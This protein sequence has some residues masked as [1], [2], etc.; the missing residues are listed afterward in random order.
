[1]VEER[2]KDWVVEQKVHKKFGTLPR[3]ILYY[4]D[5]VSD[6]QYVQVK[7]N[8]LPLIEK[9]FNTA[10]TAL[11]NEGHIEASSANKNATVKITAVVVA[12]RHHVRFYPTNTR[13]KDFYANNH[14][15]T[16]VDSVVTSPYF[17]DFYLQSHAAIKGT[18]KPAHYFLLRN[19]MSLSIQALRELTN[20]LCFTYVRSTVP[21]SYA[22]PAYYADR[23]CDRGRLYLREFFTKPH[24]K[25]GMGRQ[26]KLEQLKRKEEQRRKDARLRNWGQEWEGMGKKRRLKSQEEVER[27]NKDRAEVAHAIDKWVMDEAR[28]AFY[29]HGVGRNPWHGKIS[30][31][32]FWM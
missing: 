6:S 9:A 25:E 12:K 18:A 26:G 3:N 20:N 4:R 15:G 11:I 21:V 10:K 1:M 13:G 32:M 28:E 19:D 24:T 2:V 31:T 22:A 5:G 23:L 7:H 29:L 8:E 14:P 27:E 16:C 17:T 30:K